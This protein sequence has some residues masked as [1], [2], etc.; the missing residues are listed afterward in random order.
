MSKRFAG[1]SFCLISAILFSVRYI[2]ASI[3]SPNNSGSYGTDDFARYLSYMGSEIVAASIIALLVGIGYLVW[4]EYE[5]YN[6]NKE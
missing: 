3:Y 1:V 2:A 4:A 6:R 5:E